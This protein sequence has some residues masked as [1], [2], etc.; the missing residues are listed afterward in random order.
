[1][2]HHTSILGMLAASVL[3]L[4]SDAPSFHL[5]ASGAVNLA[6]ASSEASYGLV[7]EQPN[8]PRIISFSLGATR[9]EASLGL[10]TQGDALPQPGRYPIRL[11][12][13]EE[14]DNTR[15]FH[16]CFIAGTPE[17]PV[18]GFHGESGWVT[19][20]RVEGKRIS[21]EFELQARG[22]L[23]A[24]MDNENQW[25]T[26]RGSFVADGDSTMVGMRQMAVTQ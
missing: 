16:A 4:G 23:A 8:D 14:G 15:I 18:G 5:S 10:Y 2:L 12:W 7:P 24:N 17:H 6:I 9:G 1:M 22:M 19:I 11:T 21:G 20:T 26:V 13:P 3:S 25:V